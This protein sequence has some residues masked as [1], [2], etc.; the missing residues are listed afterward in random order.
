M[1]LVLLDKVEGIQYQKDT[2]LLLLGRDSLLLVIMATFVG[3]PEVLSGLLSSN[4]V[5]SIRQGVL[6]IM[7]YKSAE[8]VQK[9][10]RY[11]GKHH[12]TS[13]PPKS[14]YFLPARFPPLSIAIFLRSSKV[15]KL[16][17]SPSSPFFIILFLSHKILHRLPAAAG[18]SLLVH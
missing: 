1:V 17:F 13:F 9:Q 6:S 14:E 11:R 4:N 2:R 12:F 5:H 18:R 8:M 3:L 10:P 15:Q 7:V 16:F